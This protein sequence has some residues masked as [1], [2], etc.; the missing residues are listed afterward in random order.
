MLLTDSC[1]KWIDGRQMWDGVYACKDS[2]DFEKYF[3]HCCNKNN[4]RLV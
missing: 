2:N 4:Q 3:L 1:L